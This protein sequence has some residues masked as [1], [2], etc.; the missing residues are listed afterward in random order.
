MRQLGILRLVPT[1]CHFFQAIPSVCS[2][3]AFITSSPL[4]VLVYFSS[5]PLCVFQHCLHHFC[6]SGVASHAVFITS[7]SRVPVFSSSHPVCMFQHC[8][9]SSKPHAVC[10]LIIITSP[11]ASVCSNTLAI[12]Y[13]PSNHY[14]SVY[15]PIL[16]PPNPSVR[17]NTPILIPL[18]PH[19]VFNP[20]CVF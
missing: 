16:I 14:D 19:C 18:Q 15:S 4:C 6:C 11:I 2:N 3:T 13:T 17:F 7:N 10:V 20:L 5:H 9:Y 1:T 12:S 8:L